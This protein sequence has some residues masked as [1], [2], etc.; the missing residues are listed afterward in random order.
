MDMVC[1]SLLCIIQFKFRSSFSITMLRVLETSEMSS[2]SCLNVGMFS[3]TVSKVRAPSKSAL[4]SVGSDTCSGG[5]V[6]THSFTRKGMRDWFLVIQIAKP[7]SK[8]FSMKTQL[9][10]KSQSIRYGGNQSYK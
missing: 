9:S 4:A 10:G 1:D 8:H 2:S 7:T 3:C 5:V 6:R